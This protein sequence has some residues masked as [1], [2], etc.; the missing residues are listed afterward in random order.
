MEQSGTERGL[1]LRRIGSQ[2]FINISSVNK[3]T[4]LSAT[5]IPGEKR[6]QSENRRTQ[7]IKSVLIPTGNI[8]FASKTR[9]NS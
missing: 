1:E 8:G 6:F 4:M 3:S 7:Y 2:I 5:C 9:D